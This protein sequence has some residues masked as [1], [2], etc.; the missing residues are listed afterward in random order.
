M[1]NIKINRFEKKE[2]KPSVNNSKVLIKNNTTILI[3]DHLTDQ[4]ISLVQLTDNIDKN[5]ELADR[6]IGAIEEYIL[7]E[8]DATENQH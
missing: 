1:T 6:V 4:I 2:V 7:E 8:E 5:K 3:K